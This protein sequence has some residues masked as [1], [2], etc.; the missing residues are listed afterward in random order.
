MLAIPFAAGIAIAPCLAGLTSDAWILCSF[1]YPALCMMLLSALA[2]RIRSYLYTALLFLLTGCLCMLGS[3][4][5]SAFSSAA[6]SGGFASGAGDMLSAAVDRIGFKNEACAALVKALICGDRSQLDRETVELFRKSGA[7]HILALSGL[8]LGILYG[9]ILRLCSVFGNS[10]AAR[11]A[12]SLCTVA[13]T[14]I[15]TL[16]T[17]ASPSLTRAFIFICINE[18][19]RN[20][21]RKRHGA[22][23]LF[24]A[25]LIQLA[26]FPQALFSV[27]FQ[28]SYLAMTGIVFVYPHMESWYPAP[29]APARGGPVRRIWQSASLSISCQLFTAPLSWLKFGSLPGYFLISNLAALPLSSALMLLSTGGV[30]AAAFGHCP[31]LL[32]TLMEKTAALLTEVLTVISGM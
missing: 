14:G 7:S 8:H 18:A 25:M 13:L 10:P 17:G 26:I 23:V 22:D 20:T 21:E 1:L 30:I 27:G 2:F 5:G 31:D 29:K 11:R 9:L 24:T 12:R 3:E 15:Y 32:V 4:A 19:L 16:A 6:G 28:L